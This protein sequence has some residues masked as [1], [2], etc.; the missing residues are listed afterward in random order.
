M[1]GGKGQVDRFKVNYINMLNINGLY[2][3]FERQRLSDWTKEQ[4]NTQLYAA[5]QEI[6]MKYKYILD[7][8]NGMEEDISC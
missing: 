2:T 4:D 8:S 7:K 1:R 5:Y 3:P 6:Q